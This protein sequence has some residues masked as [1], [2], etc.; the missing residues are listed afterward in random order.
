LTQALERPS[1]KA[2]NIMSKLG[3]SID[4]TTIG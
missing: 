3:L 1:P 4:R 2:Y